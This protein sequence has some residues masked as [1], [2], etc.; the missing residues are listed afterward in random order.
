[1]GISKYFKVNHNENFDGRVFNSFTIVIPVQCVCATR[2][3]NDLDLQE[4]EV[5]KKKPDKYF[6]EARKW[7]SKQYPERVFKRETVRDWK[8]KKYEENFK[9]NFVDSNHE[10]F[11]H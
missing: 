1:M 5:V 7:T 10:T 2:E 3:L 4:R 8:R 6:P 11:F 9:R